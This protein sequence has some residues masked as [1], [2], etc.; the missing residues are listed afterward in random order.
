MSGC[1]A[2]DSEL[3]DPSLR[4]CGSCGHDLN[5]RFADDELDGLVGKVVDGRYKVLGRIGAGGMGVVYRVEHVRM[6]KVAAMKVL[7]RDLVDDGQAARRFIREVEV[8]SKLDHPNIVQ[9]FDFGE[10]RGLLYL[11]M[12]LV[13]GEDLAVVVKREGPLPLSRALP[14]FCQV[15]DALDEAHHL[16]VI[17]RDLKPDNIVLFRRREGEHVKVLD[18]GLAK[19]RERPGVAEVTGAASLVGTP[20]YMAPEQV[21]S[22]AVD[23]RTDI[24]ALG[25]TIYRVV[26]GTPAFTGDSPMAILTRHI[27]DAV[28]PPSMRRAGLPLSLDHLVLKAMAKDPANRFSSAAQMREAITAVLSDRSNTNDYQ[29]PLP[30]WVVSPV[31]AAS[32]VSG[33]A[34]SQATTA[35]TQV[36]V[37]QP[38]TQGDDSDPMSR[39]RRED[40][41][42]FER[43]LKWRRRLLLAAAPFVVFACAWGFWRFAMAPI[44]EAESTE[45]EPNDSAES[46]NLAANA[47]AI[48]GQIGPPRADGTPDFDYFRVPA[49]S[50]NRT[51]YATVSGLAHLNMVLELFDSE[52]RVVAKTDGGDEGSGEVLGPL[53]VG[54]NEAFLRVRPLWQDVQG[55]VVPTSHTPYALTV[56]WGVPDP[57]RELE[58]NDKQDQSSLLPLNQVV[59][60]HL[61][62]NTDVD[63]YVITGK[64]GGTVMVELQSS[65]N[66]PLVLESPQL[67]Q[68]NLSGSELK[69]EPIAFAQDGRIHLSVREAARK[70]VK[71][72]HVDRAAAYKLE[73]QQRSP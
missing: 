27:T 16:G 47:A 46:A 32:G 71:G 58:P 18:F 50:A 66:L 72:E 34:R 26:T 17:H 28:E 19:L 9:T 39:L 24:Y 63:W 49:G 41:D 37:Q 64:P 69:T 20:Y 23:E 7:R 4:F 57:A 61:G 45:S 35:V 2:C 13:R 70:K 14:L 60:G 42:S 55:A 48:F 44:E 5:P 53:R 10:W 65:Q 62:T 12:E 54:A 43:G 11:V 51:L 40:V 52:G 15:C 56:A 1:P 68:K 73:A 33:G 8:V 29:P 31:T 22:E 21:R 38:G 59:S 6:G 3:S 30:A 67:R 25:A 36:A